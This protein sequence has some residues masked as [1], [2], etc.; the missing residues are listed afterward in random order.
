MRTLHLLA[1]AERRGAEVF[2]TELARRLEALG[3]TGEVVALSG[4]GAS[5]ALDVEVLPALRSAT[6]ARALRQRARSADVVLG[7]GSHGLVG[8]TIATFASRT[9]LVYRSIGDPTYWGASWSR[10]N[11]VRL[12]LR[13]AAAVTALW[14]AAGEAISRQYGVRPDDIEIIPNAVDEA[15]FRV[16]TP[17]ERA[18]ARAELGVDPSVSVVLYLGA[19]SSEKRVDRVIAATAQVPGAHLVVAGDGPERDRV[20]GLAGES[21]AGRHHLLGAVDDVRPLFAAADVA[22]LLSA[23]EGQP[24][25]AIEAG[26]SGLPLVATDVGGVSSVVSSG[27]TGVL[28]GPDADPDEAAAAI[29]AALADR[30]AMGAAAHQRCSKMFTFA[31]VAERYDALLRQ[32]VATPRRSD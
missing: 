17:E 8:G 16:A 4:S 1:S 11:R 19:L 9:P 24:G 25:V 3:H 29:V 30:A 21:L 12:Q 32:V 23:T 5:S 15:W 31:T 7:H 27:E 14:P 6:A 20:A 28:V 13:R 22:L 2:G 26:L 18:A 10:R